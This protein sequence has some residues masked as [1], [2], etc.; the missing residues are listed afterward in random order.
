MR[1]TIAQVEANNPTRQRLVAL[2]NGMLKLHKVLLD[3]E[4]D[5]YERDIARITSSS[6]LLGLVLEDPH[7]V[8]LRELSQ[9]IV[10]VD[11]TLEW[12]EPA[13]VADA[14][15][16]IAKARTLLSP[17]ESGTGFAR[18]YYEAMQRDPNVVMAHS[19][20]L[21]VFGGL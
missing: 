4:R 15:Q 2:R 6:Q 21:K 14:D 3:S 16:L 1:V 17:S 7:F 19:A 12:E 20:M 13:T 10:L 5:I 11:E 8:W 9:L 18:N